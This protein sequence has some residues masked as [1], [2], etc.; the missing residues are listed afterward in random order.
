MHSTVG[1]VPDLDSVCRY[2]AQIETDNIRILPTIK[3]VQIGLYRKI[4]TDKEKA[5]Y[6]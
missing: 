2:L 3:R 1:I 6:W 4:K 5:L